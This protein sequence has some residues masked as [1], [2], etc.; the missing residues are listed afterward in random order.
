MAIPQPKQYILDFEQMGMGMFVHW[1]LYS[2]LGSGEW[3]MFD[4]E[5]A[6]AEYKKLA[7]TF[8]A[9]DFDAEKLAFT[10]SRAGMK[11][12]TLTT[13][14]HEGFS[15]Y[16]TCGLSDFDAPH[17]AAKRDLVAE[18]VAACAKYDIAP[19][20]YH[21]TIDWYWRPDG[22]LD[23]R[24]VNYT[25][26]CSDDIFNQYLDYLCD[27]VEILCRNYGKVGGFWFDGNWARKDADWQ[28]SRLYGTIRKYQKDAIIVN[29]TG[30][31]ELGKTGHCEL[32]S[33]TYENNS[34]APMDRSGMSKYVAAEVCRTVNSHWGFAA[35]DVN[36]MSPA[37]VIENLCHSRGCGAN[38]LLNVG[39][40]SQGALP[41]YETAL[42]EKVGKWVDVF[43]E[44]IYDVSP[45]VEYRCGGKDFVLQSKDKK[46]LYRFV[47]DL[48][49]A[50][51]ADVTVSLQ[52]PGLREIEGFE[53]EA[54]S[55]EWIDN[56]EKLEFTQD[57]AAKKLTVRC[58]GHPYGSNWCVRVMRIRLA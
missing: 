25:A 22:S 4:K 8:T 43:G 12:I 10:A 28:E 50:G 18:F 14:H 34:A 36:F 16:D 51:N 32:D 30:L 56:G 2:Q 54:V 55:A 7:A 1:G 52:G 26:E 15:L 39:P 20:F 40:E 9:A 37:T 57:H 49:I 58:T 35:K 23:S 53:G 11:Y 44:A 13:R 33:V 42:F 6:P 27:S 47:H 45:V 5:I 38:L 48:G 31:S 19:F 29:N 21:T 46:S 3:V 24:F 17:S 41:A